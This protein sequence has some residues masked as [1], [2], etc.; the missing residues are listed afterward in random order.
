MRIIMA[1]CGVIDPEN[2]EDYIA[3]DGYLALGKVMTEM[4]PREVKVLKAGLRGRGGAGFPTGRQWEFATNQTS[5][6]RCYRC[7]LEWLER[8]GE[9]LPVSSER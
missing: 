5:A 9:P 2:I 1:R 8:V 3:D 7:D 6:R 4:T